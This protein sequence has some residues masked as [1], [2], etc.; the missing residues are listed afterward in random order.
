MIFLLTALVVTIVFLVSANSLA[1]DPTEE[2]I[3]TVSMNV[4]RLTETDKKHGND[5]FIAYRDGVYCQ[6][7]DNSG[8]VIKGAAPESISLDKVLENGTVYT[9][10]AENGEYFIYD[11]QL[12]GSLWV[13]GYISSAEPS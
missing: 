12:S 10:Q 4:S 13:R 1:D 6:L 8:T 2:L 3:K 9:H 5:D 7:L 11:M